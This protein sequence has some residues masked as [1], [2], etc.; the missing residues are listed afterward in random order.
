MSKTLSKVK[1]YYEHEIISLKRFIQNLPLYM[2]SSVSKEKAIDR[3]YGVA[4]FVQ[5]FDDVEYAD[6]EVLFEDV[7][8]RI[9]NL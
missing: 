8:K 2:D 3:C 9:K 5:V 4:M 1:D 7:K 6:L